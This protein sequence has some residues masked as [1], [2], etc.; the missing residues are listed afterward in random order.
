MPDKVVLLTGNI[1]LQKYN[2]NLYPVG[3]SC[4]LQQSASKAFILVTDLLL[5]DSVFG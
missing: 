4:L 5:Q 3:S 1:I 2:K